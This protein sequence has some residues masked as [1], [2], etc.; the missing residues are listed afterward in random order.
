MEVANIDEEVTE[1][2]N[3][4]TYQENKNEHFGWSIKYV[5]KNE[6]EK[7]EMGSKELNCKQCPY[8]TAR[9]DHMKDHVEQVHKKIRKYFCGLCSYA[10]M[11]KSTLQRHIDSIHNKGDKKYKC[12]ECPYSTSARSRL[13]YHI[14]WHHGGSVREQQVP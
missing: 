3:D 8:T 11:R 7:L 1:E 12:E 6:D 10:S 13:I 4:G 14:N 9:Q 2:E 5:N